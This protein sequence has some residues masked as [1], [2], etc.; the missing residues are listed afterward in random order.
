MS[1]ILDSARDRV[2]FDPIIFID[3]IFIHGNRIFGLPPTEPTY[4]CKWDFDLGDILLNG[5]LEIVQYLGNVGSSIGYTYSD[6]ENSL[7]IPEPILYDV[8]YLS[9]TV[10]SL[11]CRLNINDYILEAITSPISLNYN[12][13]NNNRYSARLTFSVPQIQYKILKKK[14]IEIDPTGT[15]TA[16]EENY[17]IL[18]LIRTSILITDFIQKRD[19]YLRHERQQQHISM[20]DAPFDRCSFLL[21][22]YHRAYHQKPMGNIIPSI[23]LPTVPPPLT[24]ETA[25]FIDPNLS[26]S[27]GNEDDE[28]NSSVSSKSKYS[29]TVSSS[30]DESSSDEEFDDESNIRDTPCS[31]KFNIGSNGLTGN[32]FMPPES[33]KKFEEISKEFN[34][35]LPK[36]DLNPTSYYTSDEGIRPSYAV[37]PSTEYDS[38]IIQ[39]GDITGFFVPNSFLA[40]S[41]LLSVK[42][43]KDL[44]S[45]L[46]SIQIDVL[47]RLN[48]IRTAQPEVKNFKIVVTSINLKYGSVTGTDANSLMAK[49]NGEVDHLAVTCEAINISLRVS[50]M[51]AP[52]VVADYITKG[53][54]DLPTS[55][56]VYANCGKVMLSV[57]RGSSITLQDNA[58]LHVQHF[59]PMFLQLDSPDMWWCESDNQNTGFFHLKSI[60]ISIL[61]ESIPFLSSFIE[62]NMKSLQFLASATQKIQSHTTQMRNAYVISL[63]STAGE[64]FHIEDDPSVLTRPALITRST[65]HV[66]TNDSWKIMMRLRHVLKSV[67]INWRNRYDKIMLSDIYNIDT[68][69]ARREA[70]KVFRK[71]RSWELTGMEDSYVFRHVFKVKTLQDTLLSKNASINI[72]LESISL[73]LNYLEDENFLCIDYLKLSFG[74]KGK[75]PQE[76]GMNGKMG[77]S[78]SNNNVGNAATPNSSLL[79]LEC[80]SNCSSI[81]LHLDSKI[82]QTVEEIDKAILEIKS[83]L[84]QPIKKPIP[85]MLAPEKSRT[86]KSSTS[87]MS[88]SNVP[89]LKLSITCCFQNISLF[90]DFIQVALSYDSQEISFNSNI[91]KLAILSPEEVHL[92][93]S[94]VSH[95]KAI[96]VK[97]REISESKVPD[98]NLFSFLLRDYRGSFITTGFLFT[99]MKYATVSHDQLAIVMEAPIGD[100]SNVGIR[101][102][103]TGLER[104]KTCF[105]NI[106]TNHATYKPPSPKLLDI[107]K[108]HSQSV[109][110]TPVSSKSKEKQ[111]FDFPMVLRCNAKD[112]SVRIN[113]TDSISLYLEIAGATLVGK[114][115]NDKQIAFEVSVTDKQF[116]LLA[117]NPQTKDVR[118]LVSVYVPTITSLVLSESYLD[119]NFVEGVVNVK[120]I[121]ARMM[122]VSSILVMMRSNTIENEIAS[123]IKSL[124]SLTDKIN[125]IAN[126]CKS[127]EVASLESTQA[128]SPVPKPG[129]EPGSKLEPAESKSAETLGFF[130]LTLSIIEVQ[131]IIPS[132]DSSLALKL[133]DINTTLSSFYYDMQ[134]HEF[135][136]TPFFGDF[137]VNDA[138]LDLRNDTWGASSVSEIVHFQLSMSYSGRDQATKKQRVDI[139]SNKIQIV[140]CQRLLEKLV[141][142]VNSLEEGFNEF[143]SVKESSPLLPACPESSP[144]VSLDESVKEQFRAFKK[145][146][147]KTILR[148]SFS[149]FCFAWLFEEQFNIGQYPISPESKGILFGYNSLQIS[150]SNLAGKT[151]LSGVYITPTYDELNIFNNSDKSQ[152]MNTAYLPSVK[153]SFFADL[154]HHQ[155]HISVNLVGESLRLTILPSFVGLVVCLAKCFTDT[156]ES[157]QKDALPKENIN[158]SSLY[159]ESNSYSPQT[160]ASTGKSNTEGKTAKFTLPLS[161]RFSVSFDGAT[162]IL[163]KDSPNIHR[164]ISRDYH[165]TQEMRDE[166]NAKSLDN[167]TALFLQTPAVKAKI[168][169]LKGENAVKQDA[170]NAEILI[171]SSINTIY[172]KLVPPVVEMWKLVQTVVKYSALPS[173]NEQKD[174]Y[175]IDSVLSMPDSF[176]N[177][178][179]DSHFGN[180]IVDVNVRLERQ[181]II[182][183]CEPKAR[184]AATVSYDE[185]CISLNSLE[186]TLRKTTYALSVRLQNFNSS[187]QHIYSRECSGQVTVTNIAFFVAMYHNS[188]EQ[189]S[190]IVASKISDVIT[191]IN[192]KQSQDLELFQ[193]IW[194]PKGML[195]KVNSNVSL[196]TFDQFSETFQQQINS[197][198]LDGAIM[199][200]YRQVTSTAAIPWC[201]DFSLV[202][203]RGTVELGQAVGQVIFTLDK[204]WIASQKF[205][206]WEQNLSLG[207]DEIKITSQ[208]R[209]GGIVALRKIQVG[210]AI[211]WQRHNGTVYPV[212]LVQ[213]IMGIDSLEARATFDYQSFAVASINALHLSMFNQRDKNFVLN[214]RLAVVGNCESIYLFATSLAASNVL[215]LIYTIERMR[216]EAHDSYDAILRDSANQTSEEASKKHG[217]KPTAHP[218]DRLRTFLDVNINTLSIYIYPDTLM[219]P[220]VFTLKVQGAEARYSQEIEIHE[221]FDKTAPDGRKLSL[222]ITNK[223]F[224]SHLDMKLHGL[225]VALST[226]KRNIRTEEELLE[227][228]IEEYIQKSKDPK[229]TT[230]IGIPVCEISMATW[231]AVD[232]NVIEYIFN[233]S[234]G[235]RVDVGWNLGSVNFIRSMWENHVRTF[236]ARKKTYEMRFAAGGD[237][238]RVQ[239]NPDDYARTKKRNVNNNNNN[240]NEK[241]DDDEDDDENS[242]VGK[243]LFGPEDAR[244][245]KIMTSHN[246][247]SGILSVESSRQESPTSPSFGNELT[248]PSTAASYGD[249]SLAESSLTSSSVDSE[250][251]SEGTL[252]E[253]EDH[254]GIKVGRNSGSAGS[255]SVSGGGTTVGVN[256][257]SG[258][259]LATAGTATV[260]GGSAPPSAGSGSRKGGITSAVTAAAAT[261]ETTAGASSM[262]ATSSGDDGMT[263]NKPE[264]EAAPQYIYIARV[265]PVIAQPQLRDMGEATPPVEWIGLHRNKLPSFVHQVIMVPLEKT[266]EEVDVVYRKV[267]GR[268]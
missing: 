144:T 192:L 131:V 221:E 224:L 65:T 38:L 10:A 149:N 95:I 154:T 80:T 205:S 193:D 81:K 94:F 118:P 232:T 172:P 1:T 265:P 213:A 57:V 244:R 114:L 97:L 69:I 198:M 112:S 123:T 104:F 212:P 225:L 160:S 51:N 209:F 218:F 58:D 21:D 182:L 68:E 126:K 230:I 48:Y 167:D 222:A 152:S 173:K 249:E 226:S 199:R 85:R 8:T 234:F 227:M 165:F 159:P 235:G 207:F 116:E 98:K 17:E 259:G 229:G 24:K 147:E 203:I 42:D 246:N 186:D 196:A 5:P 132:F 41:E 125:K 59:R 197:S 208:G 141:S 189:Q 148:M 109:D 166:N 49:Y 264:E 163:Y 2:S 40:I 61:S 72:D 169:Y 108:T 113:A 200:K 168:E 130:N 145:L 202:N 140:L 248:R 191:E 86:S 257:A 75:K 161:F 137:N 256:R 236:N 28:N 211:M 7:L 201:I 35:A 135:N 215:D 13:L 174:D 60:N 9:L 91:S 190:V 83:K 178:D 32:A 153:V 107:V 187:L 44:E 220:Q 175:D 127:T 54:P 252:S 179:I 63:L 26:S 240:N 84:A 177:I 76:I 70:T 243:G 210:T 67:P 176:Q 20:H 11:K 258:S 89:P 43:I 64:A 90:V 18:A 260:H 239:F 185:F 138:I 39:L 150:T 92:D 233:S 77:R 162:I 99:S 29:S 23:P 255:G 37:D 247:K 139:S 223:E 4:F 22:E 204:L 34:C 30:E 237:T 15:N 254:E 106:E 219:D 156:A 195:S 194:S 87:T 171:S 105:D 110:F 50:E 122:S 27:F 228:S 231:Q 263:I 115:A 245:L 55:L 25:P 103:D 206:N 170:F 33:W 88:K 74:W 82:L 242:H 180:I 6:T 119:K 188:A 261:A 217:K 124:N 164:H 16:D 93:M 31:I 56:A 181:E 250:S 120:S 14:E 53:M 158:E 128:P 3:G 45:T 117:R 134:S 267:L 143:H 133:I 96:D 262:G 62:Q 121:Q 251:I 216:R 78:N 71:W 142:I 101:F 214:D 151:I 52:Q 268:S 157:C 266:V 129:S 111:L 184:V 253:D 155:P 19:F 12:D 73:R 66:R 238:L 47:N 100:L 46:D 36:F 241:E 183:S 146:G 136:I 102:L 79:E